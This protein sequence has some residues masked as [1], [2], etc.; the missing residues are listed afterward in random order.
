VVVEPL[1]RGYGITLGN[2]LRRVLLSSIGGAAVSAVRIEGVL[3][4]FSTIP[5]VREDVIELLMNL[6]RIPVRCWSSEVKTL[7]LEAEGPKVVTAMD[8]MPD[9]D[10][11]FVDPKA[12]ICTLEAGKR[13]QMD[14][15][16]E[17]GTG[18]AAIDRPRPAYL[19]VDALLIDSV[20][21]PV[22]R[23]K[24]EIQDK[25]MGQRTD[26]DRLVLEVQTNGVIS[27]VHAVAQAASLLERYF[28]SISGALSV[29]EP[30]MGT[31]PEE[32]LPESLPEIPVYPAIPGVEQ[33]ILTRPVRDL[34]LSV[35]SENCLLRG[36]VHLI[37]DLVGRSKEDLLKIRNLGKIS[38]REIEEKLSRFN[39]I[40]GG[41][42]SGLDSSEEGD[43]DLDSA[44]AEFEEGQPEGTCAD[45][46][47]APEVVDPIGRQPEDTE[48]K[49]E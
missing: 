34:E 26:Y 6:K 36:G 42:A 10:V 29:R 12:P 32:G 43:E 17:G 25:R 48:I 19:P 38:L 14:L 15:Y 5:G 31:I 41:A 24:Y 3:H 44:E 49:E 39:L 20:F 9:S 46:A 40:L 18:Y 33:S 13:V 23:V 8:I 16:V 1:E 30:E 22:L 27:P 7:R 37:G 35:R 2:A 21:S 4:E 45:S 28:D 47:E 11:E